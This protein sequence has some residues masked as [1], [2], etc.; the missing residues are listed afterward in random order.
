MNLPSRVSLLRDLPPRMGTPSRAGMCTA[1]A[2]VAL[3][4]YQTDCRTRLSAAF[5]FAAMRRKVHEWLEGNLAAVERGEKGDAHFEH[6]FRDNLVGLRC[7]LSENAPDSAAVGRFTEMFHDRALEIFSQDRGCPIRF[8]SEALQ[9]YGICRHALWPEGEG[10]VATPFA[11]DRLAL[12]DAAR[13]EARRRRLVNGLDFLPEPG[14]VDAV[15]SF[16]AGANG[17]RRMPVAL[18]LGP[19][20]GHDAHTVLAV[21]YRDDASQPGGGCFLVRDGSESRRPS[22]LPYADLVRRCTE[23]ATI[24][25]PME[26]YVGDGYGGFKMRRR[27]RTVFLAAVFAAAVAAA[28]AAWYVW[29]TLPAVLD[30]PF[31][32]LENPSVTMERISVVGDKT[33][34][35]CL[36]SDDS[37]TRYFFQP[38]QRGRVDA[39]FSSNGLVQA[40]SCS[41]D[42][43]LIF[44]RS[45]KQAFTDADKEAIAGYLASGGTALAFICD[46]NRPLMADFLAPYGAK[47]RGLPKEVPLKAVAPVVRDGQ[48]DGHSFYCMAEMTDDWHAM[49]VT[50]NAAA[51]PVMAFRRVDKGKLF[52]VP[53]QFVGMIGDRRCKNADWW[54]DFLLACAS[55]TY[56]GR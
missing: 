5:L 40:V 43:L 27:I 42:V 38:G 45:D 54:G 47:I 1:H 51:V 13:A 44:A 15:K 33:Y 37:I 7:V 6:V 35:T 10:V 22:I 23:A 24:I 48:L 3:L 12:P 4:E 34:G 50:D 16:L 26:D 31:D 49:V 17:N 29:R 41:P 30:A 18:A 21:G 36:Q 56:N 14:N 19:D 28:M 32:W 53:Q 39:H 46:C 20:D 55:D 9:E 25:Q 8:A 52:C 2:V 11:D